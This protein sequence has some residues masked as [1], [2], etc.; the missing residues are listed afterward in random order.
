M[1]DADTPEASARVA[2]LQFKSPR[3]KGGVARA[4]N[5]TP[6]VLR[7][8]PGRPPQTNFTSVPVPLSW[9]SAKSDFV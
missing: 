8:F 6:D 7:G 2:T 9:A 5:M 1:V 4:A 3:E